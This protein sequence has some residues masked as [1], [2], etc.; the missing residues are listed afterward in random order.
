[1]KTTM[2]P[3]LRNAFDRAVIEQKYQARLLE[4]FGSEVA[5]LEA[6]DEWR[7]LHN[8][9]FHHWPVYNKI[10]HEE[11]VAGMLPSEKKLVSFILEF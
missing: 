7:R 10:A 2:T 1:M 5:A 6:Q 11:A 8:P 3:P 9:I 4:L